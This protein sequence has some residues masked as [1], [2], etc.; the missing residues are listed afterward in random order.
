M[1]KEELE[2]KEQLR[3]EKKT[4]WRLTY[5][6]TSSISGEPTREKTSVLTNVNDTYQDLDSNELQEIEEDPPNGCKSFGFMA[7]YDA[8]IEKGEFHVN[9][10]QRDWV[11]A[12][13]KG[14]WMEEKYLRIY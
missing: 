3:L 4:I 13:I 2:L 6:T 12:S 11:L 9:S 8:N 5:S 14:I 1:D 7:R 10:A